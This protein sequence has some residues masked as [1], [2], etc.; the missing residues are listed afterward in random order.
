MARERRPWLDGA[1]PRWTLGE[2]EP[3]QESLRSR[4]GRRIWRLG[5]RGSGGAELVEARSGSWGVLTLRP[6]AQSQAR[7]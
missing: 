1:S 6:E 5:S 3:C 7:R 2:A 4:R